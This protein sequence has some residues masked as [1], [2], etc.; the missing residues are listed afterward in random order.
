MWL[1][2]GRD[3]A[4]TQSE[5]QR[6]A[7]SGEHP[8]VVVTLS[9]DPVL[10]HRLA[11]GRAH[12]GTPERALWSQHSLSLCQQ[13]GPLQPLALGTSI[14]ARP[15]EHSHMPQCTQ[16]HHLLSDTKNYSPAKIN[17]HIFQV[18][19]VCSFPPPSTDDGG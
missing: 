3:L 8:P 1:V 11:V 15:E 14:T 10:T 13:W 16:T 5:V 17:S 18:R 6:A 12:L 19:G 2:P 9:S 7:Q 4:V